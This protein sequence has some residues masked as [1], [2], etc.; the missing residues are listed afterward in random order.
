VLP[1][2][3]GGDYAVRRSADTPDGAVGL[4]RVPHRLRSGSQA[5]G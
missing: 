2:Y 3:I 5:D 1:I 4:L